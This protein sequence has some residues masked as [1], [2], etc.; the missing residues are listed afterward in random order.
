MKFLTTIITS[1]AIAFSAKGQNLK[2]LT[3]SQ[4][5]LQIEACSDSIFQTMGDQNP[6]STYDV[7]SYEWTKRTINKIIDNNPNLG[8]THQENGEAEI[9]YDITWFKNNNDVHFNICFN[10]NGKDI[11]CTNL[12]YGLIKGDRI[13]VVKIHNCK[14]HIE[15]I[16][17]QKGIPNVNYI[18]DQNGCKTVN[19]FPQ[20]K[21]TITWSGGCVNGLSNGEGT[22]QWF[23]KGKK[24]GYYTGNITNG[25]PEGEGTYQ[26]P[27]S[28]FTMG[29]FKN[30]DLTKGKIL[31][32]E[33]S[34]WLL[35]EGEFSNDKLQGQGQVKFYK[36]LSDYR[37]ENHIYTVIG[38]N[39]QKGYLNY[40]TIISSDSTV[41]EGQLAYLRANG[42]GKI[43]YPNGN[44]YEG[45]FY[46]NSLE[47][48]GILTLPSKEKYR[49]TWTNGILKGEGE[50]I[51]P[52]GTSESYIW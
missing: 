51:K 11:G 36:T 4:F 15:S 40:G 52:D 46:N 29:E 12:L 27:D 3:E 49:G 38:S 45:G 50:I 5:K 18:E 28:S 35:Y 6:N 42:T 31:I 34:F 48:N 2:H 17:L 41:Y 30:G 16:L 19:P 47:G 20:K 39:W 21:E 9:T 23:L 25:K 13:S 8:I 32:F 10:L 7:D 22:L 44:I 33:D 26:Y 1:L 37:K 43:I 14:K 24:E